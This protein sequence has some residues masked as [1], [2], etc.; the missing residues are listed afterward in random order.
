MIID[1][2][3]Y[4]GNW[5]FWPVPHLDSSGDSLSGL[6]E[7]CRIDKA[8][9]TA[10]DSI[11]YDDEMGNELVFQAAAKHP[12]CLIPAVTISLNKGGR[13]NAAYLR[14]LRRSGATA[15]KLFPF[16]HGFPLSAGN[17]RL[18]SLLAAAE[19]LELPVCLPMRLFMNW[20]L[21][22]LPVPAVREIVTAYPNI[23]F[24]VENLNAGEFLPLVEL[25]EQADN[26]LL[27]T[28]S[29][30]RYRGVYDMVTRIGKERVVG[31]MSAPMQYPQ[32]G[33]SK[34]LHAELAPAAEKL[35]IGENAAKLFGIV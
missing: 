6:L 12:D 1:T 11:L 13:D 15:L 28:A 10:L 8:V 23:R 25:A 29:L 17:Q 24:L 31:G 19:E 5:P 16:Y 7:K 3:A 20:G 18:A 2:S 33:L 32:C 34:V 35:V 21:P 4:I 22:S 9:I 27:G 26:L 30:T 14:Q